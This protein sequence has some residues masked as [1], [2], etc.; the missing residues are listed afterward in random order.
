MRGQAARGNWRPRAQHRATPHP[1]RCACHL[2]PQ[3]EKEEQ[4]EPP[5]PRHRLGME[6]CVAQEFIQHA[7][8][9]HE[10]ADVI[11]VG[12][13]DAAVHLD[14]FLHRQFGDPPGLG[15]GHGDREG[16]LIGP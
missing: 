11:L 3:G 16:G 13:A 1:S 12:H 4:S 6:P 9:L 14:A 15:L 10:Q 5:H 2:L 7:H 8:P